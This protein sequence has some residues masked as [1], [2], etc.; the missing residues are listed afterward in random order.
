MSLGTERRPS[1]VRRLVL[2]ASV[3]SLV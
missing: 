3:W 2:L 1:L